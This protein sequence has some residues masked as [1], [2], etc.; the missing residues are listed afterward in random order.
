MILQG[1]F[2]CFNSCRKECLLLSLL[3]RYVSVLFRSPTVMRWIA[4]Y[5]KILTDKIDPENSSEIAALVRSVAR[6]FI[7]LRINYHTRKHRY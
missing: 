3:H 6:I 5:F 4:P 2:E 1:V 7:R